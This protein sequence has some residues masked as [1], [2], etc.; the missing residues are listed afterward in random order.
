MVCS[1][2]R[3]RRGILR[4]KRKRL[5]IAAFTVR[6]LGIGA[7]LVAFLQPVSAT[8][9][10]VIYTKDGFWLA[11][12]SYRSGGGK[13]KENVCKIHETRFGLLAK[14]GDSQ[15]E[16]E[17]GELSSTDREVEDLLS[18]SENLEIFQATLRLRFK[19]EIEQEIVLLVND[20]EV[21]TQNL[22]AQRMI[23]PIPTPVITTLSRSIVMFDTKKPDFVGKFLLV[24]PQSAPIVDDYG[25][26]VITSSGKQLY[27]Y[28]APSVFNW[29]DANDV[30]PLASSLVYPSSVHQFAYGVSYERTNAWI[31]KNPRRA[32]TEILSKA[33]QE[34]PETIGPPYAIVHVISRKPGLPKIKWVSK[35]ACPGWTENID[36]E[37]S[38]AKL[39]KDQTN[40]KLTIQ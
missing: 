31:Q 28:W 32:L 3:R 17:S 12:D 26:P 8:M 6:L 14:S 29:H 18:S 4:K 39:V 2:R 16:T 37:H 38:I 21:T 22:A 10:V 5:L 33:H 13:H 35:G 23:S 7:L 25:R 27:R 19:N 34:E 11:A 15:G 24:E 30:P 36:Y 20:P 40:Q 9:I 1:E